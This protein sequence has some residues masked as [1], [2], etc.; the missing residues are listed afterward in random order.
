MTIHPPI[1]FFGFASLGIPAA[2]AMAA[3]VKEDW[4][5]WVRRSIPWTIFGVLALGTGLVLGGYWAYSIL[6]WGGFWAWDPVENSSLVPWLV[7]VALLHNQVI[8][9][10][11]GIFRRT[12]IF[13]LPDALRAPHLL[14]LP[15]PGGVLP[16][17]PSLLTDLGINQF[18]SR[19]WCILGWTGALRA[20][21]RRIP[22]DKSQARY[23]REYAMFWA[24]V[25]PVHVLRPPGHLGPL[26]CPVVGAGL[27]RPVLQPHG[28]AFPGIIGFSFQWPSS[29]GRTSTW[30]G[31][32]KILWPQ[33]L[34]LVSLPILFWPG[35]ATFLPG[36]IGA[37]L[38]P[39]QHV[40]RVAHH[41]P[42]WSAAGANPWESVSPSSASWPPP[43]GTKLPD[44]LP[45]VRYTPVPGS[46]E[47]RKNAYADAPHRSG[48]IIS[49]YVLP[50]LQPGDEEAGHPDVPAGTSMSTLGHAVS[51]SDRI[52]T[53]PSRKGDPGQ[54]ISMTLEPWG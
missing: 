52:Q 8:Q 48:Y 32:C 36:L 19:S 46:G 1:M 3:L 34:A 16:T 4:D 24:L 27:N 20:Q 12:N 28:A 15:D 9:L 38:R 2:Y 22:S 50:R 26:F 30:A 51:P 7:A 40:D 37:G 6:G 21:V 5:N 17:S 18:Q 31:P 47:Q 25:L 23:Q 53:G 13:P 44:G 39:G 33:P 35:C 11:R 10:K 29:S 41:P 49:P 42:K 54:A 45:G 14:H 43:P